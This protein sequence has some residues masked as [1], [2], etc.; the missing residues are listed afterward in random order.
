MKFVVSKKPKEYLKQGPIGCGA[1]SVKGILSAYGKDDKNHPFEY[2]PYSRIPFVTNSSHWTNIFRSYSLNAKRES[3]RELSEEQRLEIIKTAIRRDTPVMLLI[4]NGYRGNGIWSAVR[5]WLISHWITVWGFDDEQGVF[6]IYD[7]AV[8]RK[9][10]DKD[11]PTGNVKR[12]YK[13][14]LRDLRGGQP[15]WWRYHYITIQ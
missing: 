12:T 2:L 6:Y 15:W 13:N 9:Y 8:S 7:S 11:I 14:V 5:W 10:Y 3:M 4:G 1:F